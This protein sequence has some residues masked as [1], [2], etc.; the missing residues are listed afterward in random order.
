ML[1]AGLFQVSDQLV[2]CCG[3]PG[4]IAASG[5]DH[6]ELVAKGIVKAADFAAALARVTRIEQGKMPVVEIGYG[7]IAVA[8]ADHDQIAVEFLGIL[9]SRM[10]Q[11]RQFAPGE[12]LECFIELRGQGRVTDN[13]R[14]RF[15]VAQERC[16]EIPILDNDFRLA[17]LGGGINFVLGIRRGDQQ[18]APQQTQRHFDFHHSTLT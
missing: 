14:S 2:N 10:R 5:E 17:E 9:I 18:D 1:A 7:A 16:G 11:H 4:R 15:P 13:R 8:V 6:V 3:V 12:P